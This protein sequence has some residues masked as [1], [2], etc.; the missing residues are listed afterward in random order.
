MK[1]L[2]ISRSTLF[3]SPGGDTKQITQTAAYLVRLGLEVDI[4]LA[5]DDI[6]YSPYDLIHFFN[7]I[8]PA[9]LL[10]HAE[11]S[12]KP[13]VISTIFLDY[14]EFE[15][16][17]R[18][19]LQGFL[20]KFFS[21]DFIEYM[22]VIARMIKNGEPIRSRKYLFWGHRK[23]IRYLL[24][25]AKILLPNSVN[26]YNRLVKKYGEEQKYLAVPNAID[27]T[28]YRQTSSIEERYKGA[29]LCVARIEG[30][31]NQLNLIKALRNSP[32]RVIIHGQYSPNNK[33]Y[34][35]KCR[36]AASDNIQFSER[37]AEEELYIMF[38]SAKVHVLPSYFET[39][40][41]SSLEAAVMGCNVVITDKGDTVEYF[42]DLAFY[43]D[44]DDPASIKA[45]VDEAY[46]QPFREELRQLILQKYTWE[47][48][49]EKTL[50]A[51]QIALLAK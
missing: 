32:Y 44:P 45:A 33:A 7:I 15:K 35:E 9:D 12:C 27:A 36:E 41:L 48:A 42:G 21:E 14:G 23:S 29:V 18:K 38:H 4:R 24:R 8:R 13:F 31:K 28:M 26:E 20:N 50:E 3:T 5:K 34:Y 43:C 19:G 2:F 10:Y 11:K 1:V 49:A 37:I 39:T 51:Y 46:G 16:N 30:R 22:K 17:N 6:D 25:N 40:G 47:K